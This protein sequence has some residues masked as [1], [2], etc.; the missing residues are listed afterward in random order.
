M[1]CTDNMTRADFIRFENAR[2]GHCAPPSEADKFRARLRNLV[3]RFPKSV[4]Y[5]GTWHKG[6]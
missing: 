4:Q 1:K 5:F 6:V 2:R 3:T